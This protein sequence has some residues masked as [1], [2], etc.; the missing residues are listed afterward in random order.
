MIF[1]PSAALAVIIPALV[2]LVM[3]L[4][5]EAAA[6][7]GSA[8]MGMPG[9]DTRCGDM[10]VPYPFGMDRSECY[11]SP[12][13]NVTCDR[14]SHPPRLLVGDGTLQVADDISAEYPYFTVLRTDGDIKTDGDGRGTFGGGL[15]DDGPFALSLENEL[16]LMGCNVRATLSSGNVTM[17]SCSSLCDYQEPPLEYLPSRL[18]SSMLC[19]GRGCCQAPIIVN[20]EGLVPVTSYDVE[21]QHLGWNRSRDKELF[22]LRVF[23]AKEGWFEQIPVSDQFQVPSDKH[24]PA[25]MPVPVY[26]GWEVVVGAEEEQATFGPGDCSAQ[27]TR[28]VCRSNN[29]KCAKSTSGGYTCSC[30]YGY[31]GNPYITDGCKGQLC[32]NISSIFTCLVPPFSKSILTTILNSQTSVSK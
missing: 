25:T 20:R 30:D 9:C 15:G 7:A 24:L 22:P 21:I 19:S 10:T 12:G 14:S 6:G 32:L 23:V 29:T 1:L 5:A 17:S 4:T 11:H 26:L 16:I 3:A 2:L 13:F 8:P 31:T 28:I 27:A 18:G